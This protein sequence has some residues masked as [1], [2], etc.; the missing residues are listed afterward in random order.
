MALSLP[1][2]LLVGKRLNDFGVST[3]NFMDEE[4]TEPSVIG[5]MPSAQLYFRDPDGHSVEFISLL[6]D[7]PDA[8][9][10]GSLSAWQAQRPVGSSKSQKIPVLGIEEIV[11][12]VK[13]LERSVAFYQNVIGLS[14]HFTRPTGSLVSSRGAVA[15]VVH[16]GANRQRSAFRVYH[17]TTRCRAGTTCFG[18]ARFSRG[19]NAAGRRLVCVCARPGWEQN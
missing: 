16:A 13:N 3:R 14:L 9:F 8:N 12:Q 4:T 11:F 19:D 10:I 18:G 7:A 6:D 5:W 17:S 15:R 2:L 1:D